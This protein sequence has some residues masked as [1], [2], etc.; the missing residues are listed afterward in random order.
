MNQITLPQEFQNK[1]KAKV[2]DAFIS[3]IP[4][5]QINTVV[6][7]FTKEFFEVGVRKIVEDTLKEKYTNIVR[8]HVM[9]LANTWNTEEGTKALL[10]AFAPAIAAAQQEAMVRVVAQQ[11]QNILA[12]ARMY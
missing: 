9:D 12:N 5:E 4:E 2:L 10:V 6:D 11:V 1:I 3:I 8:Q 7:G